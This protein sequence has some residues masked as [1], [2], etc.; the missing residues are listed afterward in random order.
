MFAI[1]TP[2]EAGAADIHV[3]KGAR[4]FHEFRRDDALA[5]FNKALKLDPNNYL[6]LIGSANCLVTRDQFQQAIVLYNRAIELRP[7]DAEAYAHRANLHHMMEDFPKALS[8]CNRA[9]ELNPS[10]Y[11]ALATRAE[12][13]VDLYQPMLALKDAERCEKVHPAFK[14]PWSK[15]PDERAIRANV[16]MSKGLA[17]FD[18]HARNDA[19]KAFTQVISQTGDLDAYEFRALC[20]DSLGKS[21]E[22]IADFTTVISRNPKANYIPYLRRGW[23]FFG[24]GSY[25]AALADFNKAS[26]IAPRNYSSYLKKGYTLL[27]MERYKEAVAAFNKTI[28]LEPSAEAYIVRATA[29]SAMGNETQA[30]RDMEIANSFSRSPLNKDDNSAPSNADLK[31]VRE[32]YTKLIAWNP[33]DRNP[34]Y[35]RALVYMSLGTMPLARADLQSVLKLST[36]TDSTAASACILLH[37]VALKMGDVAESRRVLKLAMDSYDSKK[38]PSPLLKYLNGNLSEKD[39]LD[40]PETKRLSIITE[41]KFAIGVKKGLCGDRNGAIKDLTWVKLSGD[42]NADCYALAG[43]E[44]LLLQRSKLRNKPEH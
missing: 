44:L 3:R 14:T 13:R 29:Y 24:Q 23:L 21:K 40:D 41:A 9:L 6:A 26:T 34:Y 2:A 20:Y 22:A 38:W 32:R 17:L 33:R 10:C 25:P 15:G 4:A 28:E 12:V 8:D 36:A 35:N 18:L 31:S 27:K 19:I 1:A 7:R 43:R 5:E 37:L 16:L 42:K 11:P 39:V 30:K